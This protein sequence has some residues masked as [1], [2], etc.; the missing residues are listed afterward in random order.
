MTSIV[1]IGGLDRLHGKYRD[2]A[3]ERGVDLCC[4]TGREA[5]LASRVG[6][7]TAVLVVTSVISHRAVNIAR[8]R[9]DTPIIRLRGAGVGHVRRGIGTALQQLS[10][11]VCLLLVLTGCAPDAPNQPDTPATV[12][13]LCEGGIQHVAV[14]IG[15]ASA[16][17]PVRL[18]DGTPQPCPAL[19][20]AR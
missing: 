19:C 6:S 2:V 12:T 16:L 8:A 18:A 15:S 14:R 20:A 13:H 1:L 17:V 10:A 11:L 4:Y 3:A 5:D 7:A 9:V